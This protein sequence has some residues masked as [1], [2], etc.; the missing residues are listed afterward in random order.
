MEQERR[1]QRTERADNGARVVFGEPGDIR[2]A[3]IHDCLDELTRLHRPTLTARMA[4]LSIADELGGREQEH[5]RR[6]D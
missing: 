2:L 1:L 6:A 3:V 4:L 5:Q